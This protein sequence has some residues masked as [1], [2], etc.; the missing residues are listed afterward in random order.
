[1]DLDGDF[2]DAGQTHPFLV[3]AILD[4]LARNRAKLGIAFYSSTGNESDVD[5]SMELSFQEFRNE[6]NF[7][8]TE[9]EIRN[10]GTIFTILYKFLSPESEGRVRLASSNPH[11]APII[12][13]NWLSSHQDFESTRRG[14]MK[15]LQ[16]F[17]APSFKQLGFQMIP[18]DGPCGKVSQPDQITQKF[19]E[20]FIRQNATSDSHY[21]STCRMGDPA[22]ST[23]VVDPHLRVIGLQGIRVID[24][25]VMPRLVRGNTNAPTIMIAEKGAD[26][27]KKAHGASTQSPV[28]EKIYDSVIE[29]YN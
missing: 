2:P 12:N 26:L 15:M 18:I 27:I 14:F 28:L 1:V 4:K 21:A 11:D 10:N 9:A 25:S 13:A 6:R 22:D 16:F 20:C 8:V 5:S 3:A 23:T 17:T 24:A 29:N 19:A 7:P